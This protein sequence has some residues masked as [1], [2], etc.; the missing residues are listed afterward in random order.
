MTHLKTHHRKHEK[1]DRKVVLIPLLGGQVDFHFSDR[2]TWYY[3]PKQQSVNSAHWQWVLKTVDDLC[4]QFLSRLGPKSLWSSSEI[5]IIG[6]SDYISPKNWIE[7]MVDA[8]FER[9]IIEQIPL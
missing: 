5:W 7:T 2:I 8:K 1:F 3:S 4:K 6:H 9:K